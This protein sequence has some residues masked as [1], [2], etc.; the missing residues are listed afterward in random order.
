M[1]NNFKSQVIELC[2]IQMEF[3][4]KLKET[5]MET[6][7]D[8]DIEVTSVYRKYFKDNR[9]AV[10]HFTDVK[11]NIIEIEGLEQR[12]ED[13]KANKGWYVC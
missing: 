7:S 8:N 2:D 10:N 12:E 9:E 6:T 13:Y 11:N 3:W 5:L 4:K 1:S